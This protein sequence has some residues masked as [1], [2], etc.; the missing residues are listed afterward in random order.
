VDNAIDAASASVN[1]WVE[2]S[3]HAER[4]GTSVRVRDSGPGIDEGVRD[5]IFREGFTT[6]SGGA[7]Y[8]IG[9]ALV[10][11]IAHRRGGWVRVVNDGGAVFTALIPSAGA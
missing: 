2:V 9:L 6:K 10:R 11:Q 7:H 5:L 4:D 3:V 8:G 1:G